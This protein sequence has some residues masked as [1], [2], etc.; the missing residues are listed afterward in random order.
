MPT[1]VSRVLLGAAGALALS[2]TTGLA[3]DYIQPSGMTGSPNPPAAPAPAAPAPSAKP[4]K[5]EAS[6]SAE[7]PADPVSDLLRQRGETYRRAGDD[8]QN[9]DEVRTTSALNAEIAAQNAL[10]DNADAAAN[11]DYDAV[12]RRYQ[13]EAAAAEAARLRYEDESRAAEA[14]RL[15]YEQDRAAWEANARRRAPIAY[16]DRPLPPGQPVG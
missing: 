16:P 10:A 8:Q 11:A 6:V 1:P 14:A 13:D 12:Q 9:P 3:Q 7:T 15:R 5:T 2:A 4:P